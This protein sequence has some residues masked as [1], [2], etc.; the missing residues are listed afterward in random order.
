MT[1][2]LITTLGLDPY[3]QRRV[4]LSPLGGGSPTADA[5][6]NLDLEDGFNLLLENGDLVLAESAA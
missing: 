3:G 5:V 2:R 1:R 6:I 4:G